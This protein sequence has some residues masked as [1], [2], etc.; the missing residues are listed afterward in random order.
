MKNNTT[1]DNGHMDPWQRLV[2]AARR[3]PVAPVDL[4]LPPGLATRVVAHAFASRIPGT[5]S[6][7]LGW[8]DGMAWKAI[9][10]ASLAMAACVLWSVAPSASAS[11][12]GQ[13]V[14][15]YLDPVGE[16]LAMAETT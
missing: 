14:S 11:E 6:G 16:V 3:A 10:I 7:L 9:G 12:E 13:H 1:R 8:L 2:E 4:S 15:D 5:G